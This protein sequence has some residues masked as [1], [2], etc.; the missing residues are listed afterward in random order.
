MNA[1]N[2]GPPDFVEV[3]DVLYTYD[4]ATGEI[5]VYPEIG[6]TTNDRPGQSTASG[7]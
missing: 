2:D 5:K 7:S 3:V 6:G 4:D 1:N